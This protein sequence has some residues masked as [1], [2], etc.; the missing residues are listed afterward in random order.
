[1]NQTTNKI[2]FEKFRKWETN[3]L[4]FLLL[5]ETICSF[6]LWTC[7][8]LK[9]HT[10]SLFIL[11]SL[12]QRHVP[13]D[14]FREYVFTSTPEISPWMRSSWQKVVHWNQE[15]QE[16]WIATLSCVVSAYLH[17]ILFAHIWKV[18]EGVKT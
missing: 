9:T 16:I 13:F 12:R 1:M 5:F 15:R 10:Q 2:G 17:Q 6:L 8:I 11:N 4:P 3:L 18:L 14:S 7:I